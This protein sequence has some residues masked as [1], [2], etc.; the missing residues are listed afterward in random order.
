M[1]HL[2][3]EGQAKQ[4]RRNLRCVHQLNVEG[5]VS[6]ALQQFP[7]FHAGAVNYRGIYSK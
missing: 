7:Y 6:I 3:S 2:E 4:E 5:G 1:F